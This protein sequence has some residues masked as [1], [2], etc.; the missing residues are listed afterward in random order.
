ME[1]VKAVKLC[2]WTYCLNCCHILFLSTCNICCCC[3]FCFCC[4]CCCYETTPPIPKSATGLVVVVMKQHH[5][6]RSLPLD[7][8]FP[9]YVP[10]PLF[11]TSVPHCCR[12]LCLSIFFLRVDFEKYPCKYPVIFLL[13]SRMWLHDE[14]ILT[15]QKYCY[16][17]NFIRI[18][19]FWLPV[20]YFFQYN[21][22]IYI[23]VKL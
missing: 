18:V 9:K 12:T 20:F 4:C 16:I 14:P 21:V 19:V 2:L 15:S 17:F 13:V 6:Y 1:F 8:L 7:S 11:A 3:C 5:Q 23:S 10:S 22:H